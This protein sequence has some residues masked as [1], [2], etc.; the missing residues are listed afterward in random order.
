MEFRAGV[1]AADRDGLLPSTQ[2][3]LVRQRHALRV[4]DLRLVEERR[5]FSGSLGG[6]CAQCCTISRLAS[7]RSSST[8]MFSL[9]MVGL[10][11]LR[12]REHLSRLSMRFDG[13]SRT[14]S[15]PR[16][17]SEARAPDSLL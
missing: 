16:I 14:G 8:A 17:R 3:F 12:L 7:S 2:C 4:S 11:R 6:A 13:W 5:R 10:A 1:E 15:S 9:Q